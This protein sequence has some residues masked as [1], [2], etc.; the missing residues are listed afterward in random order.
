MDVGGS[1]I[2]VGRV[3]TAGEVIDSQRCPMDSA[4]RA[5]TLHSIETALASFMTRCP[6]PPPIAIGIG[7]VGQTDPASGT[8]VQSINLPIRAPVPLAA[9]LR[10]Q[11]G[12]PVCLDNDVHATT[13]AELRW[14]SG[15]DLNDFIYLNIGTGLAAGLVCNRQLV[16]GAVNYAG[17][18][19]HMIVEPGGELCSCGQ[20]G[21]LEPIASG[22]GILDQ[23][24][25]GLPEFPA[26]IL[27]G[28]SQAGDLTASLVFQAA[29]QGDPLASRIARRAVH[30]LG[31]A[32]TGLVNLLNPQAIVYGG[33]V[34]SD[35]WLMAQVAKT[36]YAQALPAA[37]RS[38]NGIWA[39]TLKTD[40][41]GLL[42]AA[43]L[44]WQAI[45]NG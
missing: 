11:Y 40:Q 9:R 28:P 7:L 33:G 32:L 30:A 8:W 36:V 15:R 14:G 13:L 1:K 45:E 34:V 43:G 23:V 42:G 20:R 27:A 2:M 4:D 26:S 18:M 22:A 25:A 19:G 17:E 41:V 44:A 37:R 38:L 5:S 3:T 6:A 10:E 24:R 12:V 29:Q 16:R 31:S 35:D 21:C 39:S